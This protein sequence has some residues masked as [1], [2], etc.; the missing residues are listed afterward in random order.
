MSTIELK[1]NFHALFDRVEK[2]TLLRDFY[3]LF[4]RR[5]QEKEGD[6][7]NNLTTEE[8]NELLLSEEESNATAVG[9][10]TNGQHGTA[11]R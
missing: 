8:Q 7:W 10:L 11:R 5:S 1:K 9:V 3:N 2:E 6:L 4:L